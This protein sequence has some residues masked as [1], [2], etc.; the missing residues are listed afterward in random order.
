MAGRRPLTEIAQEAWAPYLH[1]GDWAVDATAGNGWDTLYLARA[2]KPGGRVFA[3]DRQEA[4]ISATASRLEQEGLSEFVTLIRGDHARM[5]DTLACGVRGSVNLVCFNLG[6]LPGGDHAIMTR[7]ESTLPALHEALL[8]LKP[9][10]ALSVLAYR[11]HHGAMREAETVEGF[12]H[13][14]P[15]PW[16]CI[17]EVKS[18]S[19]D[20]PGPVWWM[21]AQS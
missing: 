10:G 7:P 11:G 15:A 9:E 1:P 5:R 13:S 6:Y 4:A 16:K 17:Q 3:I 14:L 12:F 19:E 20:N 8:L 18:G 21:A 2:V